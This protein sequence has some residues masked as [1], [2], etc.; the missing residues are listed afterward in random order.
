MTE[1][2][3]LSIAR[4]AKE[5]DGG[6]VSVV[7]VARHMLARIDAL[8]PAFGSFAHVDPDWTMKEARR[9]DELRSARG[10]AP[11]PLFGVPIGVKDLFDV[12]GMPTGAGFPQAAASHPREDATVVAR[13]R[14]AGGLIVGKQAMTAGAFIAYHPT[15]PAPRNPLDSAYWAG[16]SSSGSGVSLAAGLCLG[17]FGSDTGGSI[18]FPSAMNGLAGLKPTRGRMGRGGTV[19]LAPSLDHVGPMARSVEDLAI[20]LQ[21]ASGFD[22]RDPASASCAV[23]DYRAGTGSGISGKRIG[24]LRQTGGADPGSETAIGNAASV[25]EAAGAILLDISLPDA[26]EIA[27]NDL[28]FFLELEAAQGLR[29]RCGGNPADCG[30]ALADAIARGL[31]KSSD[32]IA[33]KRLRRQAVEKDI[34][35]AMEQLDLL[36]LPAMNAEDGLLQRRQAGSGPDDFARRVRYMAAFNFSGHPALTIPIAT[37]TNGVPISIQIASKHFAEKEL[38]RAGRFIEESFSM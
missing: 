22:E 30:Q 13:V 8:D 7:E 14:A 15:M 33:Q 9:L 36:L 5:I 28:M 2:H 27:A 25:L 23:P 37:A 21:V 12:A 35:A 10:G 29:E 4:L 31:G 26:F 17:S 32:E 18:R 3:Q 1:I 6:G 38:I 11:S 20:L 16:A 19:P 24:I 34:G